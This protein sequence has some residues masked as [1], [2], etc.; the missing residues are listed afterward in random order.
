ME[1]LKTD[2]DYYKLIVNIDNFNNSI[3]PYEHQYYI[4][5]YILSELKV[6]NEKLANEM[7]NSKI[8][9]FV[10]SQLNPGGNSIFK[11]D[12]FYCKRFV[13]FINSENR[14]LL[15]FLKN[16]FSENK[17]ILLKDIKLRVHSSY[18][19]QPKIDEIIPELVTRSPIILK[20]NSRYVAYGDD[21]F[22][23]TFLE[24]IEK[25]FAKILNKSI[26][27]RGLNIIYGK[28]KLYHIHNAPIECSVIKFIIDADVDVIR[29]ILCF[30]IGKNTRLGFGMVDLND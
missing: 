4:H 25:K 5:S 19:F 12:G 6:I 16:I 17:I 21:I 2:I 8:P 26:T 13:L 29:A 27:I 15:E 30:G 28:R 18:I 10:M 1:S 20:N 3:I 11:K 22:Y 7:Y 9:Y 24:S 23:D 14:Y